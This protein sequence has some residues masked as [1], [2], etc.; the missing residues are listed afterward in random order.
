MNIALWAVAGFLCFG[1]FVGGALLFL[2]PARYRA[3]TKAWHWVDSF[4]TP[5]LMVI[6][7]IKMAGGAGLVLPAL[8][9]FAT[10]L[11]PLAALGLMMFMT[12]ATAVR[13]V[14]R[15]WGATIGDL[16]FIAMAGFVAWGRSFGPEAF[17]AL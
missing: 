7:V 6:A 4:P 10:W 1:F 14:R 3:M 17:I 13:I 12:G 8:F 15:E 5:V 2:G 9:D 16:V 11:V